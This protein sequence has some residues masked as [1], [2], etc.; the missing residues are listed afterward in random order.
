MVPFLQNAVNLKKVDVSS[1]YIGPDGFNTLFRALCDSPVEK[2]LCVFCGITSIDIDEEHVPKCLKE[3]ALTNNEIKADGC[4][5]LTKLFQGGGDAT[6]KNLYLV[7][8]KVDAEGFGILV[9]ALH[10]NSSLEGLWLN[11]NDPISHEGLVSLLKVVNDVSS[12]KATLHSNHTLHTLE[13]DKYSKFEEIWEEI[14]AVILISKTNKGNPDGAG[15]AKVIRTQLNS[16]TRAKLATLQGVH[17]SVY[18]EIDP[19]HLPE[20]LSLV[21]QKHAQRE[22]YVA[23]KSSIVTLFSTVNEKKCIEQEREYHVARAAEHMARAAEHMVKIEELDAK[24]VAMEGI[25]G[26]NVDGGSERSNKRRR[27]WFWGLWGR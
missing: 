13:F 21:H 25:H 5:E 7:H 2:L 10:N 24:L 20:F 8:S 12:I 27:T 22:L 19:L 1:N 23:L 6:L 9:D 15:R 4:R 17:R 14:N 18:S 26:N 11:C 3:L 16:L